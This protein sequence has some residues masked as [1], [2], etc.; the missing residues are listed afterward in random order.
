MTKYQSI[1]KLRNRD[2]Q[3]YFKPEK[4]YWATLSV[5]KLSSNEMAFSC[6]VRSSLSTKIGCYGK[7]LTFKACLLT[8]C[9]PKK[10]FSS[11]VE[12]ESNHLT[13]V[14]YDSYTFFQLSFRIPYN[15]ASSSKAAWN[16][17]LSCTQ[18]N[19]F[20]MA[21]CKVRDYWER[22]SDDSWPRIIKAQ[23]S[24]IHNFSTRT[25]INRIRIMVPCISK[26]WFMIPLLPSKK[27]SDR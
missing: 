13:L 25:N 27:I 6:K 22:E 15:S 11:R 4:L 12:A 16:R 21:M 19:F 26:T 18:R 5:L 1:L 10:F 17:G 23:K 14:I 3:G 20:M 7:N 8:F 9:L 24:L 2:F